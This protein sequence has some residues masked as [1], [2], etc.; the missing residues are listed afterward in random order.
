MALVPII[1]FSLAFILIF[2]ERINR[3]IASLLGAFLMVA[4]GILSGEEALSAIEFPV[5]ASVIG[6]LILVSVVRSS[7]FF[8]W[9]AIKLVKLTKGNPVKMMFAFSLLSAAV[10]SFLGGSATILIMGGLIVTLT[11]QLN[12]RTQPYLMA[13]GIMVSVGGG[14]FL[15]GGTTNMLISNAAGFSFNDFFLNTFPITLLIAVLTPIFFVWYFK[16]DNK[17]S[18]EILMDET[19]AVSNW[20]KFYVSVALFSGTIATYVVSGFLGFDVKIVSI[21]AGILALL[22]ADFEPEKAFKEVQWE[23]LF[24]LIGLFVLVGGLKKSGIFDYV[25]DALSKVMGGF[26]GLLI[27]VWVIGLISGMMN[28]IPLVVALIPILTTIVQKTGQPAAPVFWTLLLAVAFGG[29]LTP[30]GS[31][32]GILT[33]GIG[34]N[35]G[36]PVS[37]T[38]FLKISVIATVLHLLAV[39]VWIFFRY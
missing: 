33:M 28:A 15:T 23:T 1:I 9:V 30:I 32:S 10:A 5:V 18:G 38:E 27:I 6:I 22:L 7:G 36:N 14:F 20:R 11:K 3:T 4:L 35:T 2:T 21:G 19:A 34:K 24:F 31:T 13:A 39:S 8:A 12:I 37:F 26:F 29:N 16:M 25:S 17:D